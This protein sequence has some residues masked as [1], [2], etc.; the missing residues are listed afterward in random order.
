MAESNLPPE[1]TPSWESLAG[2]V[3]KI[4]D[5]EGVSSPLAAQLWEVGLM[6][7]LKIRDKL[8]DRYQAESDRHECR[9]CGPPVYTPA[10]EFGAPD[11]YIG[12]CRRCHRVYFAAIPHDNGSSMGLFS[13]TTL[14]EMTEI[15]NR[16]DRLQAISQKEWDDRY[17]HALKVNVGCELCHYLNPKNEENRS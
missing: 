4:C 15:I 9:F 10:Q 1:A 11:A 16:E 6:A 8:S 12:I 14:V 3:Q 13:E 7:F 17:H 2:N 5:T